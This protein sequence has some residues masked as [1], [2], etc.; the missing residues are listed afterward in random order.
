MDLY[1][2]IDMQER[3]MKSLRSQ[4]DRLKNENAALRTENRG[5]Q[6]K[7]PLTK[8]GWRPLKKYVRNMNAAS[9]KSHR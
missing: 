2:K 8:N 6:T 7:S 9:Q 3:R 1:R 5:C 4:I